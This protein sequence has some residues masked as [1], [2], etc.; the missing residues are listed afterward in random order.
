MITLLAHRGS[1]AAGATVDLPEEEAHHLLVRRAR[2]GEVLRLADGDG[3]IGRG[4]LVQGD[5][6]AI[7]A[8]DRFHPPIPLSL[9]VAV[10]DKDRWATLAEKAA[11][12]GVTEL[13]PL[14]T[15]RSAGVATRLRAEHLP[16][17]QRRALE[18]IKQSGTAWAPAIQPMLSIEELITQ[19]FSGVR[20]LADAA[21]VEAALAGPETALQGV[22]GPEGGITERERRLLTDGGFAP[23]RL[24]PLTMRFETAALAMAV[25]AGARRQEEQIV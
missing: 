17:I 20:W 7:H 12:L 1:L 19:A 9:A 21:G 13:I 15:E 25:V 23:V 16:R 14:V 11:E 10:A 5:R 3:V 6:V 24:G 22:I 18:A 8:V 2:E 4:V